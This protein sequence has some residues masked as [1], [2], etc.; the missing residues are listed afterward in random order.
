MH[1]GKT[2]MS[3]TNVWRQSC[4]LQWTLRS[5]TLGSLNASIILQKDGVNYSRSQR[6]EITLTENIWKFSARSLRVTT[7]SRKLEIN[8]K[9]CVDKPSWLL[10][11]R[12]ILCA[13][14]LGVKNQAE[15]GESGKNKITST[16]YTNVITPLMRLNHSQCY[17]MRFRR[18]R[19][20]QRCART[21]KPPLLMCNTA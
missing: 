1:G 6:C 2:A 4:K 13:R 11:M 3:A 15:V 18:R 17:V 9:Y 5:I 21:A 20:G 8:R 14:S 19:S 12:R 10:R 16:A 7:V